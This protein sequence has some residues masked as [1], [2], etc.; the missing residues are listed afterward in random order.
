[1]AATAS[2]D[3]VSDRRGWARR[4]WI[5]VALIVGIASALRLLFLSDPPTLVFDETYYAKDACVYV[6]AEPAPCDLETPQVEAHPPLGKWLIGIGIAIFGFDSFGWRISAAAA[7]S[8]TVLLMYVL[9]RRLLG[10]TAGAVLAAALMTFD[11]LHFVQSRIAMLDVFVTMFG[12]AAVLFALYDR[13][14]VP[15]RASSARLLRPYRLAAGVAAGGAIASKWSGAFFMVLVLALCTAWDVSRSRREEKPERRGVAL[16]SAISL[17]VCLL[18]VPLAVYLLTFAGRVH[19]SVAAPWSRGSWLGAVGHEQREMYLTHTRD[20]IDAT[21]GYQ[22]PAWSWILLKRPV[23][24]FYEVNAKGQNEEILALGSPFVWWASI[25]AFLYVAFSWVRRL[26]ERRAYGGAEGLIVAGILLTYS[27]WLIQQTGRGA[28]FIFYLLPTV[29]FM[30]LALAYCA[31][32]IGG[33]WEARAAV[34]VFAATTVGLFGYFYPVLTKRPLPPE[35]WKGRIWFDEDDCRFR[36]N[37]T[38]VTSTETKAGG[39]VIIRT[40]DS[41]SEEGKPPRGWCWI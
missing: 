15:G 23:A 31:T 37:T 26:I 36:P 9:G 29:P 22:S 21:H 35:Q 10:S 12:V 14:W 41:T 39:A 3:R 6:E 34:A 13:D 28:I 8:L 20:I 25:P 30:C 27:P 18:L 4:D 24:Y 38:Q 16:R 32:R 1:M 5:A 11:F 19:G 2:S 17:L 33:S 7:G 40:S